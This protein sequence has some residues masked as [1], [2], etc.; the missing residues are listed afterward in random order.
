MFKVLRVEQE[1]RKI[2]IYFSGKSRTKKVNMVFRLRD[3]E[4]FI[5]AA[6]KEEFYVE[7]NEVKENEY[8]ATINTDDFLQKFTEIKLKS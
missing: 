6:A 8:M 2:N 1:E 3:S 4:R 5:I 7:C